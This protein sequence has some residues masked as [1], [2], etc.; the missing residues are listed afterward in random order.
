[1]GYIGIY[2]QKRSSIRKLVYK[3]RNRER[4]LITQEVLLIKRRLK[5]CVL[6]MAK[7]H[8]HLHE[9]CHAGT[10][11]EG[12]THLLV[13]C[14]YQVSPNIHTKYALYSECTG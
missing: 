1:M 3:K 13:E 11:A 9:G 4:E 12:G 6:K 10:A 14:S 2:S 5:L 8:G 7:D